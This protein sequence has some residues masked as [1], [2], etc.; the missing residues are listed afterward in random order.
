M[1]NWTNEIKS[2]FFEFRPSTRPWHI[3]VLAAFCV[4]IP[5][6]TGYFL[7]NIRYGVISS[8]SGLV[9]LYL[10]S[11]PLAN[12]MITL[13]ACS[14]GIILSFFVGFAFS[15]NPILSSLV[16]GIHAFS[17]H[18]VTSYFK[19]KAPGNFFFIMIASIASCMPFNLNLIPVNVGLVTMGTISA[20]A[21]AFLFKILSMTKTISPREVIVVNQ[22]R[23]THISESLV[24]GLFLTLSLGMAHLLKLENPYWVPTSCAAVMQGITTRQVWR[25]SFHRIL[26]TFMGLG[27]AWVLLLLRPSVLTVCIAIIVLQYIV[28]VIV[29]RNYT[30]AAIFITTLT[31]FLAESM[32]PTI[33]DDPTKL[34]LTRMLDIVIGSAIGALGG[35][36]LYHQK[37]HYQFERHVRR[38]RVVLKKSRK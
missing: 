21:M 11:S 1:S 3:P 30:V 17:V 13:I 16:L 7:G 12:Q 6:L 34:I 26:G 27:L 36:V 14:F 9:I 18:W 15:F 8:T 19:L 25:R 22:N 20:C 37:L 23:Y 29:V 5:I 38:T 35:W 32:N 10:H 31:I 28:E 2:A 4:G 24:W 33:L